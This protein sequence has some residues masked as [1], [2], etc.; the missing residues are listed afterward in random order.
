MTRF[1]CWMPADVGVNRNNED[2]ELSVVVEFSQH[3]DYNIMV[4]PIFLFF[5]AIVQ[6]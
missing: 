2:K 6:T 3:V 5:F 1:S 4:N